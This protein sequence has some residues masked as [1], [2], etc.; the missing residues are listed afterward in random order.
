V[1]LVATSSRA[2]AVWAIRALRAGRHWAAV[3]HRYSD[4]GWRS[5]DGVLRRVSR[6]DLGELDAPAAAIFHA[7]PH[8]VAGPVHNQIGWFVF[9]VLRT[10]PAGPTPLT[11][12]R[13]V[14]RLLLRS[15]AEQR[16]LDAYVAE[17]QARW[18]AVTTCAEGYSW[19]AACVAAATPPT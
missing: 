17:Y 4:E 12:R 6:S 7:R 14:A 13:R 5:E 19:T 15:Q 16:A 2:D 11:E 8:V 18:A 1:Q 10:H 3:V 9:R